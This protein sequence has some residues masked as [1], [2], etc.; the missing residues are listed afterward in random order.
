MDLEKA[1]ITGFSSTISPDGIDRRSTYSAKIN[2]SASYISGGRPADSEI[3]KY[4]FL[5]A[6]GV[7]RGGDNLELLET[8]GLYWSSYSDNDAT[9]AYCL[10]FLS[11]QIQV[12]R[13]ARVY[14]FIA[15][16]GSD[17]FK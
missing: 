1:N 15:G 16:N 5:P 11:D 4:F 3:S 7:R 12:S 13:S 17:W 10:R 9:Y 6:L 14:G 8:Q 2:T